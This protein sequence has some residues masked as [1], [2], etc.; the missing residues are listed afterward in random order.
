MSSY[1][2]DHKVVCPEAA[3][4]PN[5]GVGF[6]P[7]L[8]RKLDIELLSPVNVNGVACLI[9]LEAQNKCA[10]ESALLGFLGL[11]L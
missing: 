6:Q 11:T 5:Y 1:A 10:Y 8:R 9:P 3:N 2:L 7:K 4:P